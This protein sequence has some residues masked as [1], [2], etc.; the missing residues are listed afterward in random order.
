MVASISDRKL[1]KIGQKVECRRPVKVLQ[2]KTLAVVSPLH[3]SYHNIALE[4]SE[5]A[6]QM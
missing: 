3:L 6:H 4:A 5:G 2:E 1:K